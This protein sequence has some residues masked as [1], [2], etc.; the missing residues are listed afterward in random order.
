[1]AQQQL[2]DAKRNFMRFVSHEV[3]TPLNAVCLGLSV[4]QD[5]IFSRQQQRQHRQQQKH[6]QQHQEYI[7]DVEVPT[8]EGNVKNDQEDTVPLVQDITDTVDT[9][10]EPKDE[11]DSITTISTGQNAL[12]EES[13]LEEWL[14][15][16]HGICDSAESSVGVLDDLLNYDKIQMK[17][18][19]MEFSM[20]GIWKLVQEISREFRLSARQKNMNLMLDNR[21]QEECLDGSKVTSGSKNFA[22]MLT[23][24]GEECEGEEALS[25][26]KI[27]G[28]RIRLAQ[29]L[30]NI[31][32]NSIKFTNEGGKCVF[33]FVYLVPGGAY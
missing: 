15:L 2:L 32:S 26:F 33:S 29:V 11:C 4:L 17:S 30:R 14:D 27:V 6:Q 18:F 3:R 10:L 25:S 19:T 21:L 7:K 8:A 16:T 28:D 22:P 24:I 12:L 5:E 1:M 23:T 20:F 31:V 13:L 9:D